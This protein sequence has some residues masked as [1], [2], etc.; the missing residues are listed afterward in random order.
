MAKSQNEKCS[1]VCGICRQKC[2]RM[3]NANQSKNIKES[4]IKNNDAQ[5]QLL[6]PKYLAFLL[7]GK[8]SFGFI[9][10]IFSLCIASGETSDICGVHCLSVPVFMERV[11]ALREID[12]PQAKIQI[13]IDY[14][15]SFVKI[16]VAIPEPTSSTSSKKLRLLKH[17]FSSH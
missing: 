10:L 12:P 9:W 3:V 2:S 15:K 6:N 7:T 5:Q 17:T 11:C 16:S 14:G 8:K 4:F 1:K 13:G